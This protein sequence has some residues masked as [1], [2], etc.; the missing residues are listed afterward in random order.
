M[1]PD[2]GLSLPLRSGDGTALAAVLFAPTETP[3]AA[4]LIAPAMGVPASYY[5]GFAQWLAAQGLAVLCFD[6]RGMGASRFGRSLRSFRRATVDDW[7]QD[8]DAALQALAAEFPEAPLLLLGHSLGA[9]LAG[10][11]P[12]RE[13]LDGVLGVALGSG[14][15]GDLQ[16]RFRPL[17]RLFLQVVGPLVMALTGAFPGHKL[18]MVGD[19]PK[20]ALQQWRRWCLTSGYLLAA[21]QRHAL[22]KAARFPL[23]SVALGDDEMLAAS[24]LRMMYEAHGNPRCFE[25]LDPLPGQPI[26]HTGIFKQRHRD[27]HWP[28]LL[29]H[30]K[31]LTPS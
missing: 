8:Q 25:T 20:G 10:S 1:D 15:L 4:V 11:L 22:Y 28:R 21:E 7:L 18:G 17:A 24:G 31:A 29:H 12:S 6:Y 2:Q 16:P 27:T 13:R 9:Q 5:R 14:Y 26:G 3:W 23:I 30:L 19:L